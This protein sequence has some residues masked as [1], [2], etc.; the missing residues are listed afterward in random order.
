MTSHTAFPSADS[1]FRAPCRSTQDLMLL[2]SEALAAGDEGDYERA[3]SLTCP[4]LEDQRIRPEDRARFYRYLIQWSAGLGNPA[5]ARFYASQGVRE[6]RKTLGTTHEL[7]LS[8]RSSELFWMCES[9][10][11]DIAHRRFPDLIRDVEAHLESAHEIRWAVLMNSTIPF[12]QEGNFLQAAQRYE[13]I[14]RAMRQHPP[15]EPLLGLLAHDNYAELLASAGFYERSLA[16]YAEVKDKTVAAFGAR[17]SRTL[18]LRNRIAG[19]LFDAG[20]DEEAWKEWSS[21][22]PEFDEILGPE[23][24]ESTRLRTLILLHC[25]DVGEDE[26]ALKHA[27]TLLAF[28]HAGAD[29]AELAVIRSMVAELRGDVREEEVENGCW[30]E[31][32]GVFEPGDSF[33]SPEYCP[34]A[35]CSEETPLEIEK[36]G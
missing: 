11:A 6:L 32:E 13:G 36:A 25:I 9:G 29:D 2:L 7:T 31:E 17:D 15:A 8:L 16:E 24:P 27:E 10:M 1:S 21:L 30:E 18:R 26:A 35:L 28:P 22:L 33:F 5:Q 4:L 23:H 19:V 20:K 14:L 3:I 12:K 34:C